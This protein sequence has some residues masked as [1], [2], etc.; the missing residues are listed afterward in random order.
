MDPRVCEKQRHQRRYQKGDEGITALMYNRRVSK[1]HPRLEACG[2]VD[3]LTSAIGL[4]RAAAKDRSLCSNLL[5]LQKDLVV[6]MGELATDVEDLPRYAKDG[7]AS[8]SSRMTAKLERLAHNTSMK[9]AKQKSWAIPGTNV[10]SAALDLARAICRRAERRVCS[11]VE[12][13]YLRN[14]EVIVYLN[15]LSYVLWL[16]A[17]WAERLER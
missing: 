11:L 12:V 17:R 14:H 3:E 15:R 16:L 13:G 8:V 2:C 1:C 7:H 5:L 4:A 10:V 9:V 6:L